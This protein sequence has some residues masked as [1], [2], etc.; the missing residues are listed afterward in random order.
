MTHIF[1]CYIHHYNGMSN[2]DTP[3]LRLTT[4]YLNTTENNFGITS[5]YRFIMLQ[6][7]LNGLMFLIIDCFAVL[8]AVMASSEIEINPNKCSL[9]PLC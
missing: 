3:I 6:E 2:V 9:H 7:M 8:Y 4:I 1:L 5:K